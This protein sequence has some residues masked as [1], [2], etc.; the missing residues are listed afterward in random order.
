VVSQPGPTG[1]QPPVQLASAVD[2]RFVARGIAYDRLDDSHF[3]V[4]YSESATTGKGL[5]YARVGYRGH[6]T[7]T[8][9]LYTT[10]TGPFPYGGAVT[11]NGATDDFH[12]GYGFA[13][14]AVGQTL[15]Y[16]P[17]PATTSSGLSCSSTLL[18]WQG[19]Q[20][21]GAEFNKVV[22]YS[23]P[24]AAPHLMVVSLASA[25]VLV[26]HPVVVSGCRLLVD[27]GP[28]LLGILPLQVGTAVG[29]ELP[30][31]EYLSPTTLYFQD[32]L[33]VGTQLQSSARL[34]VPIVK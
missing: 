28:A 14:V 23:A 7:E 2:R 33:L 3:V 24:A 8:G 13:D 18:T 34:V 22:A 31:P 5:H 21:I 4:C 6:P 9:S 1:N 26:A 17:A 32:W 11:F 20:Q 10:V 19:N 27:T 29:W 25:N 15:Q 16:V 12:L 30:L